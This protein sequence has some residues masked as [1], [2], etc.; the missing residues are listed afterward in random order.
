MIDKAEEKSPRWTNDKTNAASMYNSYAIYVYIYIY[1]YT[2]IYI[3]KKSQSR[4]CSGKQNQALIVFVG[5]F[6]PNLGP[7]RRPLGSDRRDAEFAVF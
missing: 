5:G 2:Y 3:F 4:D 1:I 7:G 6:W